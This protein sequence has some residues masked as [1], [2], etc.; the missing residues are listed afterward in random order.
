LSQVILC[1]KVEIDVVEKDVVGIEECCE[2]WREG[3]GVL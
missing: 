1:A 2:R 3:G